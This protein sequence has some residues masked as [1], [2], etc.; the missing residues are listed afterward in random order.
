MQT[1]GRAALVTGSAVRVGRAIALEL[2]RLGCDIALHY[3]SSSSE[4]EQTAGEIRRLARRV[5]LIQA[6]LGEPS[7]P[8]HIVQQ[9]TAAFGRLDILVNSASTF[10]KRPLAESD[11]AFWEST[12]RVNLLAPALLARAA[13][14]H[15]QAA[16]AGRI[17]NMADIL[18]D[19]PP[20]GYTAYCV[21][22]AAIAGLTRCLAIELAPL[23]TVNAIAPGIA[24]FP[25]SYSQEKRDRLVAQVP[26][27]RPGSPEEVAA[28]VKYLVTEGD[29]V[30]GQVI[31]LDGG[32]S[33]K[34]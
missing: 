33:L 5:E 15:M 29:Y 32:R 24:E 27:Q 6:D 3:R 4:A 34:L 19:R 8:E 1:L 22:K 10:D 7:A 28:L 25:A 23:V 18:A 20:K 2:A 21:S 12:L 13:A 9:A 26:L 30:T 16:G 14:P 11:G 17:I 31:A